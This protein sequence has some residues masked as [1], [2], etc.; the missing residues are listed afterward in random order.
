MR[1]SIRSCCIWFVVTVLLGIV[2]LIAGCFLPQES[3]QRHL[4]QSMEELH[5]EGMYSLVGDRM[6]NSVLDMSTDLLIVTESYLTNA[7]DIRTVFSNPY[8]WSDSE[9]FNYMDALD[10][11]L[12]GNT[13]GETIHYV[14]YWMGFRFLIRALLT[15]LNF[16]E[17]RRLLAVSFFSMWAFACY[18][19]SKKVGEN[20]ALAL[21]MSVILVKP[22]V[23][24]SCM[25][26]SCCFLIAFG[27]I[28][29]LP[30]CRKKNISMEAFFME[31]GVLTMF[32]DFYSTPVITFGFPLVFLYFLEEQKG[33]HLTI[34]AMISLCLSWAFGYILMW[35]AKL[36]LT[37]V[38]TDINAWENAFGAFSGWMSSP[39]NEKVSVPFLTAMSG[40][41]RGFYQYNKW[42]LFSGMA[43]GI[44]GLIYAVA[45]RKGTIETKSLKKNISVL[46]ISVL[47]IIWLMASYRPSYVH[48]WFQYRGIAVF[49][50]AVGAYLLSA[51]KN[52][53]KKS[54]VKE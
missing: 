18:V 42:L 54:E 12:N 44:L 21:A 24:S 50:F 8:Y 47:P 43:V 39:A 33:R 29:L 41:A 15:I 49:F 34:K 4:R 23:V 37:T 51:V 7:E 1:K 28:V 32:F 38:F 52:R 40:I 11:L 14:R 13:P 16:Y 30:M 2:L 27:A 19:I 53:E 25:Q 36:A 20:I 22:Q 48:S 46:G 31:I 9:E 35:F 10:E 26:Y 3:I 17:I 45:I 5:R 6:Y